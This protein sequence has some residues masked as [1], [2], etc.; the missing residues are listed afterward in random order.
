MLANEIFGTVRGSIFQDLKN[1]P[2]WFSARKMHLGW[3]ILL[4]PFSLSSHIERT[5]SSFISRKLHFFLKCYKIVFW[6]PS[7]LDYINLRFI[8]FHFIC[9]SCYFIL[10]E[11]VHDA[12]LGNLLFNKTV[13]IFFFYNLNSCFLEPI[14][15]T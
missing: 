2:F 4:F 5:L 12:T 14:S 6:L 13:N 10:H 9:A 1:S 15:E 8:L 7:L 11:W 3:N